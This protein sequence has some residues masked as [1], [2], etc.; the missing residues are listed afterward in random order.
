M[1]HKQSTGNA[2]WASQ[3]GFSA[4]LAILTFAAAVW[5][6]LSDAED[7]KGRGVMYLF[8]SLLFLGCL[9]WL[10]RKFTQSTAKQ[11]AVFAW[12][13][14]QHEAT[15]S[16]SGIASDARA[17]DVAAR[18]RDG[19]LTPEELRELQAMRPDIPYPGDAAALTGSSSG[20]R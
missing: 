6:F 2:Y 3:I 9:I 15:L 7:E 20:R 13:I 12:A 4:L 5:A 11:R 18:A 1:A 14:M 10:I 16:R 8:I 17:M 19:K